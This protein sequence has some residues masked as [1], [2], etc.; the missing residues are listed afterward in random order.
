[1]N[2][3][4]DMTDPLLPGI[5]RGAIAHMNADHADALLVYVQAFGGA[6]WADSAQ[7]IKLNR[8]GIGLIARAGER[9]EE[10]WVQF[11]SPLTEAG[12]LRPTLIALAQQAREALAQAS[13]AD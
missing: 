8:Y 12:Q 5:I 13:P 7:L 3:G 6:P 9:Q 1:M 10:V 11:D 2:E 4:M